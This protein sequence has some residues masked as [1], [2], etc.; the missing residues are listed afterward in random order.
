MTF[1][2]KQLY[3]QIHPLKL[4]TDIS[5]QILSLYLFWV[6]NLALGLVAMFAPPIVVSL[7]MVNT[8]DFTRIKDSA[9]GRYLK[10]Y[11]TPAMEAVRLAGTIPISL[12]A[13]FHIPWLIPVGL[14]VTVFGWVR[15]LLFPTKPAG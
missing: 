4:A 14:A 12:G 3:H 1:R 5:A 8:M 7:I 6:H 2:E 11:M 15:G 10:R 9:R 13:W